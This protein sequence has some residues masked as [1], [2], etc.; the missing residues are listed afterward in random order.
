MSSRARLSDLNWLSDHLA[1]VA[2]Q[3]APGDNNPT[4]ERIDRLRDWMSV[5]I[6]TRI[7]Q[8]SQPET[9]HH[10]RLMEQLDA[11]DVI[12]RRQR[13]LATN[14]YPAEI[15]EWEE[16]HPRP[17][18]RSFLIDQR[19]RIEQAVNCSCPITIEHQPGCPYAEE[20]Q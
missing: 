15:A 19:Q 8:M 16:T 18:L 10:K 14:L 6:D 17:T 4:L 5:V 7:R 1:E 11:A 9:E 13:E 2:A 12:W 20:N 3:R